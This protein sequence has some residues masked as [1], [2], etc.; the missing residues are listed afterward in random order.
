MLAD[1]P[2]ATRDFFYCLPLPPPSLVETEM[3][4][5]GVRNRNRQI[6]IVLKQ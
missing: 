2:F 5:R 1:S 6:T 4:I 3:E